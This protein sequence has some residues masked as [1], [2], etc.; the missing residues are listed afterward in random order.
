[1]HHY[2][3]STAKLMQVPHG[4]TPGKGVVVHNNSVQSN[5]WQYHG[6]TVHTN[7]LEFIPDCIPTPIPHVNNKEAIDQAASDI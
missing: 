7:T 5:S 2:T 3:E 6:A 1:M 4:T